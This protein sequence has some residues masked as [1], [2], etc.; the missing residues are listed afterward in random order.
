MKKS[1]S[2]K[3]QMKDSSTSTP[4]KNNNDYN[5]YGEDD[6]MKTTTILHAAEEQIDQKATAMLKDFSNICSSVEME[7]TLNAQTLNLQNI[8]NK[9]NSSA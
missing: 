5:F 7:N 8:E 4:I 1:I 9:A 6:K 2:A 3:P